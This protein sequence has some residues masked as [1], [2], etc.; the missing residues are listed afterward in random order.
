MA[1]LSRR[2]QLDEIVAELVEDI[3]ARADVLAND[4]TG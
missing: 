3:F 4:R 2:R 1:T